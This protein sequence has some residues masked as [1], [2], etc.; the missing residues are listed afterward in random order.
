MGKLA[1]CTSELNLEGNV[2]PS[3]LDAVLSQKRLILEYAKG[4]RPQNLGGEYGREL[5]IWLAPGDSEMDVVQNKITLRKVEGSLSDISSNLNIA[6]VGYNPEIYLG[7]EIQEG[8]LRVK[9]DDKGRP[10]KPAY[11]INESA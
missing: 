11:E 8:G 1:R 9:R 6:D 2:I 10:I 4:L 3:E 7:D 5:E